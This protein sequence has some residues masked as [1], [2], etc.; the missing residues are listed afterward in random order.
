[1]EDPQVKTGIVAMF[2]ALGTRYRTTQE[3]I[4]FIKRMNSVVASGKRLLARLPS[5]GFLEEMPDFTADF[6]WFQ[7]TVVI[8]CECDTSRPD[9]L[10]AQPLGFIRSFIVCALG[11]HIAVR[12]AVA[13]GKYVLTQNAILGPALF[14]AAQCYEKY[15]W[16][17]IVATPCLGCSINR[18][19]DNLELD[20]QVAA[21]YCVR[22]NVPF[23]DKKTDT[24]SQEPMW[25]LSWPVDLYSTLVGYDGALSSTTPKEMITKQ[26]QGIIY[27]PIAASK[28]ENTLAFFDWFYDKYGENIHTEF[29]T[30]RNKIID[31]TL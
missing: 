11:E 8:T 16:L 31:L 26:L 29:Q 30:N 27:D 14:D 9:S 25:V 18:T 15:D 7:D 3:C 1:M 4:E 10:P 22:Y 23:I 28:M 12:G 13:V 17:G 19:V 21:T 24:R 5:S 6:R 20:D 2:D